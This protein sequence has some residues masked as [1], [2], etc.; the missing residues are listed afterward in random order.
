MRT[1]S[2]NIAA[3]L[4]A[5]ALLVAAPLAQAARLSF[6]N[7]ATVLVKKQFS[8]RVQLSPEDMVDALEGEVGFDPDFLALQSIS[9]AGSIVSLWIDAPRA[10]G[11]KILF[12]GIIPG[13]V[14][15]VGD[16]KNKVFDVV[17]TALKPGVT[18]L[19][20]SSSRAYLNGEQAGRNP[21]SL[22]DAVITISAQAGEG[23]EVLPS[24]DKIPPDSFDI[25]LTGEPLAFFGDHFIVFN[26]QD[27]QSGLNH[28]EVRELFLGFF[29]R[30]Q[31]VTSPYHL[32]HQSL[33]SIIRVSALD[34]AGNVRTKTIIPWQLPAFYIVVFL[35]L[36]SAVRWC[37][38]GRKRMM[39]R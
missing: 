35:L 29:G 7:P 32:K 24:G 19:A 4:I 13:G 5:S 2:K 38:L 33:I 14:G 18:R 17:F 31:T 26:T 28:Y 27:K 3:I 20:F 8:V 12:S 34:N 10:T 11:G 15:P 6:E 22:K 36:G 21:V 39:P 25:Y 23:S 9:D 16:G 37:I 1:Y 30:W